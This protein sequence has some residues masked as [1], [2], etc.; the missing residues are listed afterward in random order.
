MAVRNRSIQPWPVRAVLPVRRLESFSRRR[1]GDRI[2]RRALSLQPLELCVARTIQRPG[3]CGAQAGLGQQPRSGRPRQ[4][5]GPKVSQGAERRSCGTA[6]P[7][8]GADGEA[9]RAAALRQGGVRQ[10]GGRHSQK[11][12][13]QP[14]SLPGLLP[15]CVRHV[16]KGVLHTGAQDQRRQLPKRVGQAVR[17]AHEDLRGGGERGRA[18]HLQLDPQLLR[19]LHEPRRHRDEQHRRPQGGRG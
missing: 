7:G 18:A 16:R 19:L 4:R 11:P 5:G 6:C 12:R 14:G 2:R 3:R 9:G 10:G 15:V 1:P 13:R 17:Q 8:G